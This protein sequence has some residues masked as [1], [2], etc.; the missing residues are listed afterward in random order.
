M[1][2]P[3]DMIDRMVEK[4]EHVFWNLHFEK[5]LSHKKEEI[6]KLA[7]ICM[8][9]I[10]WYVYAHAHIKEYSKLSINV[11][12]NTVTCFSSNA[13]LYIRRHD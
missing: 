7:W 10:F 12:V 6:Q 2:A 5:S 13:S 8:H 1:S 9:F 4:T 3:I 11:S